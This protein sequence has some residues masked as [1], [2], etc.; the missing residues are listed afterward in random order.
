MGATIVSISHI[1]RAGFSVCFEGQLCKIKNSCKKIIG[2]ILAS[3]NSLHKVDRVY[4]AIMTQ[5]QVNL[6]TMHR[7]LGHIALD[8]I[9]TLFWSGTAE[10]M[11]LI[12][13]GALL[14]CDLC[15]HVKLTQKVICRECKELLAPNFGMEVHTNLWGPSLVASMG[16]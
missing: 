9:Q 2:M 13:N 8:A 6:A 4:S 16:G 12:D 10:G 5:E 14:I 1:A 15:E 11:Q 3:N 7:C